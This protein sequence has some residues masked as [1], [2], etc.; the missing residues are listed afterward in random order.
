MGMA[1]SQA[2][3]LSLIARKSNQEFEGQQINQQ[4]TTLG[5]Q[6]AAYNNQ[7]L[8]LKVPA[9]PST[10]DYAQTNYNLVMNGKKC[11][12]TNLFKTGSSYNVGYTY[13]ATNTILQ[14]GNQ[15][16]VQQAGGLYSIGGIE[17]VP[18]E[19]GSEAWQQL[20]S[21]AGIGNGP[22]YSYTATNGAVTYFSK[23]DMD[24]AITADNQAQ[25]YIPQEFAYE[26]EAYLEN[27]TVTFNGDQPTSITL[28]D[29]S[30][31]K[32]NASSH[33][34]EEAY[35]SAMN[36]YEYEKNQYE[37]QMNDI[38]S[39][40]AIIQAQDKTLELKLKALDTEHNAT[41]TE[42]DAVKKVI[43]KNVESSFKTFGG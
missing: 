20:D 15:Y 25:G 18:V 33:I 32:I 17:L 27:V 13:P 40:L 4:R 26:Q 35:N 22:Y 19:N 42:I 38:N 14:P 16:T 9:P 29:G 41:Q 43:D 5:N 23:A 24:A 7:L 1:A 6:S 30:Q 36:H 10:L 12:I 34:D 28:Q 11:S 21:A 2:R 8:S 37:K 3:F 31:I 39:K